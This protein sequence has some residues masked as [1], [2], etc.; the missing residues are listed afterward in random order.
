LLQTAKHIAGVRRFQM[1][2]WFKW[3]MEKFQKTPPKK[4]SLPN[5]PVR[6]VDVMPL[7]KNRK[8]DPAEQPTVIVPDTKL[9]KL[10]TSSI[11]T[12]NELYKRHRSVVYQFMMQKMAAGIRDN[13]EYIKFFRLGNTAHV[14]GMYRKDF[15]A[16][17]KQMIAWFTKTEE[18]ELANK[19]SS[20]LKKHKVNTVIDESSK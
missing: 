9:L 13:T 7:V 8:N 18:Y 10:P 4:E 5:Q 17:L 1:K 12:F 14:A 3:I 16:S 15:E 2:S 11:H 20:L 19:A 6:I